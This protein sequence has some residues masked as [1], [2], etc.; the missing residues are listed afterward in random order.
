MASVVEELRN[1]WI[2]Q[3]GERAERF[4]FPRIAGQLKGLLFL[5]R[6]PMSLEEMAA[7]LEVSKA[8]VST[9]IRLLERWRVV[10]RAYNRGSRQNFY[11]INGDL[12]EIET[13]VIS[14]IARDELERFRKHLEGSR[15]RIRGTKGRSSEEKKDLKHLRSRFEELSEY[16]DA[17]D[18]LLG[19]LSKKKKLTPTVIKK[20]RIS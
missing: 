4:G 19:V 10:R 3:I 6:T 13:E 11:E 5:S 20:I 8:S 17:V 2:D 7:R 18:H 12:W 1:N 15:Q 16:L 14:T 9:N